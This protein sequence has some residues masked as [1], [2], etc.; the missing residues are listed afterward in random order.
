MD[1]CDLGTE[2][3]VAA[4]D[5]AG[6]SNALSIAVVVENGISAPVAGLLLGRALRVATFAVI[7]QSALMDL[8]ELK[9][10]LVN[11][12]AVAVAGSKVSSCPS[13]VAAVPSLFTGVTGTLMMPVEG[14]IRASLNVG[15]V[16][17]GR[18]VN[19]SDDIWRS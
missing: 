13:M 5:L 11:L 14:D 19:V 4:G 3:V 7:D 17:R 18:S 2:D 12:A 6:N 9:L 10:G 15:S 8:E 16:W 1:R